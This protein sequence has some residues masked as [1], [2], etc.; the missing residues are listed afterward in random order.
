MFK[1][2]K[3]ESLQNKRSFSMPIKFFQNRAKMQW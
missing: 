3:D 1:T 2:P